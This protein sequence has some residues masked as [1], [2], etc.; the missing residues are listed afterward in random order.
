MYVNISKYPDT[1]VYYDA[2]IDKQL[3]N[4]QLQKNSKSRLYKAGIFGLAD[5]NQSF[6]Q[7]SLISQNYT[8]IKKRKIN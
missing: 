6:G 5:Q 8:K 2:K 3:S 7:C 1:C 4:I